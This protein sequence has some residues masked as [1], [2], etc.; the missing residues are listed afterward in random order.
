L[1]K[2]SEAFQSIDSESS[3]TN[4]HPE[5]DFFIRVLLFNQKNIGLYFVKQLVEKEL[6]FFGGKNEAEFFFTIHILHLNGI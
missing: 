5:N 6:F 4:K 3:K 2:S 1:G